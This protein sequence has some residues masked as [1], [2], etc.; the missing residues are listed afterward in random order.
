MNELL[1]LSP[2]VTDLSA[3]NEGDFVETG[4]YECKECQST[5]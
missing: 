2:E 5:P 4:L 3:V 1:E